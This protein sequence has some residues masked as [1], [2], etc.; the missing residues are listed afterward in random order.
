[1]DHQINVTFEAKIRDEW[2][3]V[4][5]V[6]IGDDVGIYR[7]GIIAVWLD[8]VNVLG[9]LHDADINDLDVKIPAAAVSQHAE[10]IAMKGY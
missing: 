9:L 10:D 8:G 3:T 1:M 4:D 2:V 7:T 6:A 5:A